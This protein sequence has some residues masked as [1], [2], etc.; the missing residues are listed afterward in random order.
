LAKCGDSRKGIALLKNGLMNWRDAGA[1][2]SVSFF[3]AIQ[4]QVVDEAT[5]AEE[6]IELIDEA[7]AFVNWFKEYWWL[8]ELY[9]LKGECLLK[10]DPVEAESLLNTALSVARSQQSKS[11]E[12]RSALSLNRLWTSQGRDDEAVKLVTEIY[13]QFPE[14]WTL[15]DLSEAH[16]V[17]Q[18]RKAP[19]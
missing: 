8:A 4:T 5:K 16:L 11:L 13:D 18:S 12:L 6:V 10:R 3:L 14:G 9:R 7:H 2:L 15:P 19:V 17:L 1:G